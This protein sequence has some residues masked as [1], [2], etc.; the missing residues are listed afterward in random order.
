MTWS[1]L[2]RSPLLLVGCLH[3]HILCE[4]EWALNLV[5]V[6]K[7]ITV[8]KKQFNLFKQLAVLY[9]TW[10]PQ[11]FFSQGMWR[12][13]VCVCGVTKSWMKH[14]WFSF[15]DQITQLWK[16]STLR[17]FVHCCTFFSPFC[18][19]VWFLYLARG[20]VI[21]LCW[22]LKWKKRSSCKPSDTYV[23]KYQGWHLSF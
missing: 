13:C 4:R 3:W 23:S 21:P 5:S 11:Q 14:N 12:V 18:S 10:W 7:Q 20:I 8:R 15:Q 6:C 2:S 19:V 22:V 17:I 1:E 16:L 9:T